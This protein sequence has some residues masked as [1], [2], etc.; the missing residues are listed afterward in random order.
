MFDLDK[1]FSDIIQHLLHE[2]VS[3]LVASIAIAVISA[4]GFGP[5]SCIWRA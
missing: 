3:A 1:I 4:L 2:G 5:K